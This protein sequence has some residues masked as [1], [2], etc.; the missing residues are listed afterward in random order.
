MK[1]KR[2]RDAKIGVKTGIGFGIMILIILGLGAFTISNIKDILA[3]SKRLSQAFVPEVQVSNELERAVMSTMENVKGF[4]L[5]FEDHYLKTAQGYIQQ[6]KTSIDSAEELVRKNPELEKLKSEM[7]LIRSTEKNYENRLISTVEK[8][9]AIDNSRIDM[10]NAAEIL[11]NN[12][13]LFEESQSKLMNEEIEMIADTKTLKERVFK[14]HK[15]DELHDTINI[16]R[17]MNFKAQAKRDL[18]MIQEAIQKFQDIDRIIAE[19]RPA[20]RLE[21]NIQQVQNIQTASDSYKKA[22]QVFYSNSIELAR[23]DNEREEIGDQLLDIAKNT[24]DV[25]MKRMLN[26]TDTNSQTLSTLIGLMQGG[27]FL[28]IVAGFV[29]AFF[30]TRSVTVPVSRIKE[31]TRQFGNGDLGIH[32]DIDSEDEIGQMAKDLGV[33]ISNLRE[34]FQELSDTANSL[35]GSSEELSSVSNEM[36]T[37]AEEMN[38][39][40][41]MVAAASEQVSA[42]VGTVASATEESS[43]SVSSIAAMTEEMST[44]F[45]NVAKASKKTS[46]NASAMAASSEDMSSQIGN[47]ASAS[48]EMTASLNEVAKNTA[49][50]SK[51][52][53][54]ANQRTE[55]INERIDALVS[56][57]KRIG[58]IVSVIKDIADQTNMLALNATIEAAGAGDAGKGFAVVAGEVKELA[59]Q[60]ADATDEIAGQIDEIQ[61]STNDAVQAIEEINKVIN[62]IAGINE[63]I[64]ASVEEQTAT[65]SEI[66]KSVA[67]YAGSVKQMA[68]DANESARLVEEIARSTDEASKTANEIAKNIEELQKGIRDVAM[69]ADGASQGVND[70]SK[71]IR[72]I[73][74]ASKQTAVG[75]TQTHNSS[76]ELAEMASVLTRII[77]RFKL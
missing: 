16:I 42:S 50:A 59:R 60:S 27:V 4:V 63:M 21:K 7:E 31:Y 25:G 28:A 77:S 24:A 65:A 74:E 23:I 41:D 15:V 30:I 66:S 12:L 36:A 19:I 43:S 46:E 73:S 26:V 67:S 13:E 55:R 8:H 62:E 32:I 37:S 72:S 6:I 75:A 64:A 45:T 38:S 53:Q 17:I 58:K 44:S 35:A 18:Q 34:I 1:T 22:M 52:S 68:Q 71:N 69:S 47:V 2:F 20:V 70:I 51:I 29:V 56:S 39:Q 5:S 61:N 33:A 40:A 11:N 49:Q 9:D 76:Q 3:S 48:E 14:I 54:D 57:S 10:D